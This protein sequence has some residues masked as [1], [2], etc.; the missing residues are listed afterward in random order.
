MTLSEKAAYLKGLMDGLDLNK[1]SAEGKMIAGIV[2]LLGEM[3][4]LRK[5]PS[6]F[7][8]SWMKLKKISTPLRNT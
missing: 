1:E 2:D 8:M 7:P 3:T 5:T 6:R 4:T